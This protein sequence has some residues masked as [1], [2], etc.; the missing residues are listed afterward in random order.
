MRRLLGALVVLAVIGM[1]AAWVLTAP[2]KRYSAAVAGLTGDPVAG[3]AVFWASGCA[4]CHMVPGAAGEAELVLAGGMAFASAF[5][6]FH[7]P[8]ISTDTEH[9]IGGW[10]PAELA[11]AVMD[12]VSPTGA[13][14]HTRP[15]LQRL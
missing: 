1:G 11:A 7:A 8:N 10:T 6:T 12:G 13:H 3:E 5:G 15:A 9:G 4:S 2:T 14:L